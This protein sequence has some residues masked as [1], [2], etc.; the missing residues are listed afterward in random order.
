M[1][2][3]KVSKNFNI[4]FGG[5]S[6]WVTSRIILKA[7]KPVALTI[8]CL[9]I[10]LEFANE[11]DYISIDWVKVSQ[12]IDNVLDHFEDLSDVWLPLF[13]SAKENSARRQ[14]CS[15]PDDKKNLK[16]FGVFLL[17]CIAGV[18]ISVGTC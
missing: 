3:H 13:G 2:Q 16:K 14:L 7:G 4:I 9:I 10:G 15:S 18:L 8:G 6:G 17:S 11:Q 5:V 1:G 12:H